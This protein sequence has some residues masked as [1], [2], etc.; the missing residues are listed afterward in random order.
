MA[1][2]TS[3]DSANTCGIGV[4]QHATIPAEIA[5]LFEGL[6]ETLELHRTMLV[7]D[8]ANARR[9]DEV[10]RELAA[11]WRDIAE[12]VQRAAAM[13]VAQRDLPMGAH[14]ETKWGDAHVRAFEKFVNAESR[15]LALLR[16]AANQDEAMLAGLTKR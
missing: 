7:L 1:R 11:A 13:M 10:Y 6:G 4:A 12:R 5:V 2:T 3:A 15:L 16:V 14:D 9:E 8:D